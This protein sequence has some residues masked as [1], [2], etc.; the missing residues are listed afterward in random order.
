LPSRRALAGCRL[1]ELARLRVGDF[2]SSSD[3]IYIEQSKSGRARHVFLAAETVQF[4][5]RLSHNREAMEWLEKGYEERFNPGVL[6]RL[7]FDLFGL[8]RAFKT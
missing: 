1:G 4:C 7:G 2:V 8:T 3:T 6:L 5:K